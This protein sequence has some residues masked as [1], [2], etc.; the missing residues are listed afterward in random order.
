[1]ID[2][3]LRN[4]YQR[5]FINPFISHSWLQKIPPN[6]I[7]LC[8]LFVG[9]IASLFIFLHLPI[10]ALIMLVISGF[11]D[12]VDGSLARL[13]H[14]SSSFGSALDIFC[15]RVVEFTVIFS[16][17]LYAPEERGVIAL[18][19]LGSTLL[20]ITSFLVVGIFTA[21]RS[22]KSFYY[23]SGMIERSEAFIFFAL[24]ILFP[25]QFFLL[26]SCFAALTMLTSLIRLAEFYKISSPDQ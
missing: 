3:K 11:L 16:L 4:V 10:P 18:L 6:L 2:S 7:T 25:S 19:M 24:M 15:D 23:S 22:N 14:C 1:M 8:S 5:I 17:F 9:L 26:G 13:Q 21:N 20:C 12:T